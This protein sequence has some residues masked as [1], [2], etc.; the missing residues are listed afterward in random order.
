MNDSPQSQSQAA[1]AK[2]AKARFKQ[3]PRPHEGLF[4]VIRGV[5]DTTASLKTIANWIKAVPD[6][7]A[8]LIDYARSPYGLGRKYTNLAQVTVTLGARPIQAICTF[9]L[10]RSFIGKLDLH[11]FSAEEFWIESL[12]RGALAYKIAQRAGYDDPR[13]ALI[14]GL[15]QDI[16]V[17]IIAAMWP[18]DRNRLQ[19]SLRMP[20]SIR[21]QEE[22]RISGFNHA[23]FLKNI[24]AAWRL[25]RWFTDAVGSHHHTNPTL[26]DRR[27]QRLTQICGLADNINEIFQ[28]RGNPESIKL[29]VQHLTKLQSR[30]PLDL[31]ALCLGA[32]TEVR[33]I[34]RD[35]QLQIGDVPFEMSFIEKAL[36]SPQR[37]HSAEYQHLAD[38]LDAVSR[39]RNELKR[40]LDRAYNELKALRVSDPI[41][42]VTNRDYFL[43][44]L[45]GAVQALSRQE[46]PFSL[47]LVNLDDFTQVNTT[48]GYE[49]GDE[50]LKQYA[51]RV[52][53]ILRPSDLIGRIGNDTLAVLLRE[54]AADGGTIAARRCLAAINGRPFYTPEEKPVEMTASFGGATAIP[55][56]GTVT[57]ERLLA[58]AESALR[59][60][61]GRKNS[62]CW[63]QR[64]A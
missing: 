43:R 60:A 13:E 23:L 64:P 44:G 22:A 57:G 24:G 46:A 21:L 33:E 25:N 11:P 40:L 2:D 28:S 4:R 61:K 42:E 27:T 51:R 29:A 32:Q 30:S 6:L 54:A 18:E 47:V 37:T 35:F 12:R 7:E 15:T 31:E 39:E 16:G 52:A 17:L 62:V 5:E 3:L 50:I 19:A 41:T 53:T 20:V 38:Q 55:S 56:K 36:E 14:V 59:E 45:D 9:F 8:F 63:Y 10:L 26:E 48:Y 1:M 49:I 58:M 34:A